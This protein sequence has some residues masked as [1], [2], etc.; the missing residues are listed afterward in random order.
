MWQEL[1]LASL[2][3]GHDTLVTIG[4]NIGQ[5]ECGIPTCGREWITTPQPVVLEHWPTRADP[6]QR[7]F[8]SV[9]SWRGS[10]GPIEFEGQTYGLRVHEFR[11]FLP[12][13]ERCGA[14]FELALDIHP[15]ETADL[16]RL[17]AHGWRL[18]QPERVAGDIWAYRDYVGSSLGEL[19][20]AKNMYVQT[21]GGWFSDRSQCYLA[22]GRPVL[23]QETGFSRR[24]PSGLGLV[25][26][27]TLDD[28]V[29]G[30][31]AI[32]A[33]YPRH[34]RRAHEIAEAYFDSDIVLGR[35]LGQLGVA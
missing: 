20:V 34:A 9:A 8:S 7:G 10:N 4:E 18:V 27:E 15:N 28:A 14:S 1:G 6:P 23:A 2:F 17:E 12:L 25:A 5:P 24:Y 21:R 16:E 30:A 19:M 31:E 3:D 26:F 13:P 35:L 29:A 32:S 33:D 22:A 11:K